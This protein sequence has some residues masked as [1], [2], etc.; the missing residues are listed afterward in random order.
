MRYDLVNCGNFWAPYKM[1]N[2]TVLKS[3]SPR[4]INEYCNT[5]K[6]RYD[7]YLVISV[8]KLLSSICGIDYV[9]S[10]LYVP[11]K[12]IFLS[13]ELL[14]MARISLPTMRCRLCLDATVVGTNV[15]NEFALFTLVQEH[16]ILDNTCIS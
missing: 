1:F 6:C 12:H 3:Q 10:S 9:F 5:E 8:F 14:S 13:M 2:V 11:S 16:E 4:S 15:S 7:G